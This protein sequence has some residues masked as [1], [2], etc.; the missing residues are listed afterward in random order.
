[1]DKP[2]RKPSAPTSAVNWPALLVLW[3]IALAF[4]LLGR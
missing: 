1:M 3:A 4:V 2:M